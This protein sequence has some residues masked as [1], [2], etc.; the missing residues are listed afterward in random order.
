MDAKSTSPKSEEKVPW[1]KL[2]WWNL[3]FSSL[4]LFRSVSL[5]IWLASRQ[6]DVEFGELK[7]GETTLGTIREILNRVPINAQTT[8]FELGCGRGRAAFLFHFL[9]GARVIGVDLVSS[10]IVTGRRLARWTG[11]ENHVQFLYEN[12]LQTHLGEAD[13]VYACALCLEKE[14]KSLLA[15]KLQECRVGTT[16]VTIGW[17]PR[18]DWL[19]PLDQFEGKFSWGSA[20]VY[21]YRVTDT[22][23][24]S[25]SISN[26]SAPH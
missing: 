23:L 8:I 19:T 13:V 22:T 11:C 5:D 24:P 18:R 10:F 2:A 7:F 15:E 12:F 25:E 16:V 4:Y 3:L 17:D 21:L 20:R 6:A 14:S 1:A 9:T 26:S